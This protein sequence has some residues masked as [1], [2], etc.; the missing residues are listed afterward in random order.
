HGRGVGCG[1]ASPVRETDAVCSTGGNVDLPVIILSTYLSATS[2]NWT[3]GATWTGG[4]APGVDDLV[5]ISAGHTVTMDGNP[6]ACYGLTIKGSALWT[7]NGRTT[8]VGLAGININAGG[9]VTDISKTGVLTTTGDLVLNATTN[10]TKV[11]IVLQ[12]TGDQTISG[13]GSLPNLVIDATTTNNGTLTV[14]SALSGIS[15]LTNAANKSLFL[16][17][18]VSIVG[19]DASASGN[20]V[21]Y[22]GTA[23]QTVSGISPFYNLT[24]D[25]SAGVTLSSAATV[26]NVLTVSQGV[27]AMES[28]LTLQSDASGTASLAEMTTGSVTGNLEMQRYLSIPNNGWRDLTSPIIG[29][30]ISDW[31]PAI[32][33]M[34]FTGATCC[35]TGWVSMY[36]FDESKDNEVAAGWQAATNATNATTSRGVS[37]YIGPESGTLSVVGTPNQGTQVFNSSSSPAITFTQ[38]SSPDNPDEDG[39]NYIGNPYPCNINWEKISASDRVNI[40]DNIWIYNQTNGSFGIYNGLTNLGTEGVDSIIPSSQAFFIHASADPTL[41]L[42]ES[43]KEL[44]PH[45]FIKSAGQNENYFIKFKRGKSDD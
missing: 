12:T 41:T 2:G 18:T 6:A 21:T 42:R 38:N 10:G 7:V 4:V 26:T 43:H 11:K 33:T 28:T 23:A 25:N 36:T 3:A 34:G 5:E 32:L 22:N 45:A 31:M 37:S 13:T 35:P 40:N 27:F 39:F 15:T 29:S 30:T 16:G 17:G 24:L 20:T 44:A 19:L 9:D 1:R 14:S 8:N